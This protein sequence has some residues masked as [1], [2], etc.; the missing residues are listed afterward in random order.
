MI[1]IGGMRM[2]LVMQYEKELERIEKKC[3]ENDLEFAF[4]TGNFPIIAKIRP[5]EDKKNQMVM[6]IMDRSKNF[7]NGEI[8]LIFGSELVVKIENDFYIEDGILNNIK[9]SSKK[10]HYLFLQNYFQEKM[11]LH[12]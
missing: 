8:Q 3:E 7:V 12:G 5:N 1:K 2:S 11:K 9:T 4:E 6:D 10:I